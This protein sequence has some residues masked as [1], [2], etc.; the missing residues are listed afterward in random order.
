MSSAANP[1]I[2]KTSRCWFVSRHA[3]AI[4]W[5]KQNGLQVDFF[6]DHLSGA[7]GPCEGDTVIGNLPIHIIADLNRRG[8]RF[9]H[10]QLNIIQAD[11]GREL[12]AEELAKTQPTLAEYLVWQVDS[13]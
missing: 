11:R 9:I 13:E 1:K 4:D 6:V 3:G 2:D 12:T 8:I 7:D 5:A 10:L